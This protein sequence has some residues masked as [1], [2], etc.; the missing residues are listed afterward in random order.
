MGENEVTIAGSNITKAII[1]NNES[2]KEYDLVTTDI[3]P[4]PLTI[5]TINESMFQT[6]VSG[7]LNFTDT[8]DIVQ[9]LPVRGGEELEIEIY[10]QRTDDT[11]ALKFYVHTVTCISDE[12]QER[13]ASSGKLREWKL[14]F[15]SY[16]TLYLNYTEPVIF[17]D[18]DDFVTKIVSDEGDEQDGLVNVLADRFFNPSETSNSIQNMDVEPT[19]NSV[20]LK[21]NQKLYPFRKTVQQL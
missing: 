3:S 14:E 21:K 19:G 13:K 20:W 7:V 9:T 15:T 6:G 18:G 11:I 1:R 4:T 2:G 16:E 5:L 8:G 10:N 12:Q 17:E